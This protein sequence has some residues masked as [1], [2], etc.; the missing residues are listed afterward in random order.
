M[1][2]CAAEAAE[3]RAEINGLLDL[4]RFCLYTNCGQSLRYAEQALAKSSEI[5]DDEIFKSLVRGS[6]ANLNL[7]LKG[8]RREDAEFCCHVVKT[9]AGALDPWILLRRCSLDI[10]VNYLG[11][12]YPE[13]FRAAI[14]GK[15]L[16]QAI[17]DQ[18]YFI[19]FNTMSAFALL[20]QGKWRELQQSVLSA[21]AMTEKNVNRHGSAL[22]RLTLGWLHAEALDFEGAKKYC[23]EALDC[24]VE[25]NPFAF[26]IGRNLLAKA[27][28]GLRDYPGAF[29]RFEEIQ[30]RIEAE[31]IGLDSTIYPHYHSN[32]S[33]YWLETGDLARARDEAERVYEVAALPP[34]RTYLALSHRLLALIAMAEEKLEEAKTRITQ[35]AAIVDRA[36]LPLAAWRVYVAAARIYERAGELAEAKKFRQRSKKT[37]ESLCESFDPDEPLRATLLANYAAE[38][39]R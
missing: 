25:T 3:L 4:S 29:A 7:M 1:V 12:N 14:E 20:H 27:Y 35:A 11:S 26:F 21:L 36:E 23:G 31:G 2:S 15:R 18:Y 5:G 9:T 38:G 37:I 8:W 22:C 33:R 32:L 28:I 39:L 17:G 19:I 10:V 34:E 13:S 30:R 16:A 6:S 24:E